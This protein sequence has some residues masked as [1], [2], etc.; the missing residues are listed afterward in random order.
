MQSCI[1]AMVMKVESLELQRVRT[2]ANPHGASQSQHCGH[3]CRWLHQPLEGA[4]FVR[5]RNYILG[6]RCPC[7]WSQFDRTGSNPGS[8]RG[9]VVDIAV[10]AAQALKQG[11]TNKICHPVLSH[12]ES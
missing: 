5:F 4:A 9:G 10:L 2:A 3:S 7:G 6:P 12:P 8:G 1:D 11:H